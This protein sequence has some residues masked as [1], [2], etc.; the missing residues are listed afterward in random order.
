MC[1][2]DL[3]N[4]NLKNMKK[5]LI[6]LPLLFPTVCMAGTEPTGI[7]NTI[8]FA[9]IVL[10]ILIMALTVLK[11]RKDGTKLSDLMKEKEQP[12]PTTPPTP[13]NTGNTPPAGQSV[14][15]FI[16]FVT[17]LVA[18]VIGVCLT[19]F[20]IYCHFL[21]PTKPVDMSNLNTVIWGMGIGVIPYGFNKTAT[22]LKTNS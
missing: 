10:F 13:P 8:A 12:A 4:Q 14:S 17:G 3:V 9:P 1:C 19:T 16:A 21:D 6:T 15:R 18:L 22:A 20:F 2:R 7:E 11:L 5:L